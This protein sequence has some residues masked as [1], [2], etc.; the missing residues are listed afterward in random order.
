MV[1]GVLTNN[2]KYQNN[3]ISTISVY[4]FSSY[5]LLQVFHSFGEKR[6]TIK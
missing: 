4:N 2:C 6:F 5:S 3:T 1:L